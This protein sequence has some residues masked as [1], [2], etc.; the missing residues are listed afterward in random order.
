MTDSECWRRSAI[1]QKESVEI[2]KVDSVFMRGISRRVE[3]S[4]S[5]GA[6]EFLSLL[7]Q[8]HFFFSSPVRNDIASQ[9]PYAYSSRA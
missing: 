9:I 1:G 6:P 8:L 7:S 5:L 4:R 2:Q 3:R